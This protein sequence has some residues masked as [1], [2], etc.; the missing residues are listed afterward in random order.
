MT[1]RS[2]LAIT[3]ATTLAFCAVPIMAM[4]EDAHIAYQDIGE[5]YGFMPSF[6]SQFPREELANVWG[7]FTAHQMNPDLAIKGDLRELIGVAVAAQGPCPSCLYFHIAAALAN[8]ASEGDI[9]MAI[10]VAQAT[11]QVHA[12]ISTAQVASME[13]RR[14][15]DLVL[16]G[17]A[18]TV[19]SRSP[20]AGF[21]QRLVAATVHLQGFC[22]E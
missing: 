11:G 21:C 18:S 16:W 20:S 8:G 19:A 17:D 7:A 3:L 1:N 15:T 14:T 9:L 12:G 22:G 10:A 6:F 2:R 5:T 4:G 13:F